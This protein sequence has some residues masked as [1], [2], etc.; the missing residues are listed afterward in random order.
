MITALSIPNVGEETARDIA[1]H[2]RSIEKIRKASIEEFQQING[3]GDVVAKSLHEWFAKKAHAEYVD[4]LLKHIRVIAPEKKSGGKFAGKTFVFTGSIQ[5]AREEA[6]ELVRK[7]GG[8]TS[9]SVSSKTS[10]VVAGA[11]AGSKLAKAQKLRIK[12]LSENEFLDLA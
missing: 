10:Y 9:G 11:E 4:K 8:K 12:V 2:F 6:Q 3:V 1:E 7:H 5:M